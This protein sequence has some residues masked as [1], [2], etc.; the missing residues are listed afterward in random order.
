MSDC[1]SA[2]GAAPQSTITYFGSPFDDAEAD[3]ILRSSDSFDFRI[4]RSILEKASPVIKAL[5]LKHAGPV[6]FTFALNTTDGALPVVVLGER[7]DT[8]ASLLSVIFPV[9]LILPTTLEQTLCVLAAAQ[10]YEMPFAMTLIRRLLPLNTFELPTPAHVLHAFNLAWKLRLKQEA[11]AL[12]RLSLGRPMKIGDLGQDLREVSGLALHQLVTCRA[13]CVDALRQ[14]IN[15]FRSSPAYHENSPWKQSGGVAYWYDSFLTRAVADPKELNEDKFHWTWAT[16][17]KQRYP[18]GKATTSPTGEFCVT[19][20]LA[21]LRSMWDTVEAQMAEGLRQVENLLT[22][23]GDHGAVACTQLPDS[24]DAPCDQADADVILRS[25]DGKD[26]PV[27]RAILAMA[28]PV[29]QD[30]FSLPLPPALKPAHQTDE[31]RKDG[32]HIV[33]M[34]ENSKVLAEVLRWVYPLPA[35][36]PTTFDQAALLI[37]C[38]L[39]YEMESVAGT[40]RRCLT[41]PSHPTQH[42]LI[43]SDNAL[44]V[45]ALATKYRLAEECHL[46]ARQTLRKA[47]TWTH[48]GSDL[49]L[50]NG[51]ALHELY[52]YHERCRKA[53]CDCVNKAISGYAPS[54]GTWKRTVGNAGRC[55]NAQKTS[56]VPEWWSAFLQAVVR[57]MDSDA[58]PTY[59]ETVVGHEVFRSGLNAHVKDAGCQACLTIYAEGGDKFSAMLRAEIEAAIDEVSLVLTW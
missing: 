8:L 46:A 57:K 21:L 43:N 52:Q 56:L 58:V 30:M 41:A 7:R 45:Y 18:S 10:K 1:P 44:Q 50:I 31:P 35:T 15:K 19:F 3:I 2:S 38:M 48:L 13:H 4:T 49:R 6:T 9:A 51:D 59:E 25:S 28:S 12:A 24:F 16:H 40:L 34:S 29:F 32:L 17:V 11:V 27:R 47:L 5:I 39:K 36:P 42:V 55:P 23:E 54:A 33:P 26:F 37:S 14:G 22:F 20:S 53:V